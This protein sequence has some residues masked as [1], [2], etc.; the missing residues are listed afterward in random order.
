MYVAFTY[1]FCTTIWVNIMRLKHVYFLQLFE[2]GYR[3]LDP[4]LIRLPPPQMPTE[5]LLAA[6]EEFYKEDT[7]DKPRNK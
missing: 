4:K 1:L 5:R 3:A 6:V 2:H 7:E